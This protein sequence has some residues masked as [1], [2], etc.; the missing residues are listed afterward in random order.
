MSNINDF[1]IENG[2]LTKYLG[3]DSEVV[4]PNGVEVIGCAAFSSCM[5]L[6]SIII[7][8]G[9]KSIREE[10]FYKCVNLKS[11]TIP[12]SV[13]KIYNYAF[14]LC[15]NIENIYLDSAQVLSSLR[16]HFKRLAAMYYITNVDNK[17]F[18]EDMED[19]F[20][21]YIKSQRNK[22]IE[23]YPDSIPLFNYLTRLKLIA[24]NEVDGLINTLQNA[25]VKA[26]LLEYK[27]AE[28]TTENL[29]KKQKEEERSLE[30][31]FG[32][33]PTIAEAK[34]EWNLF[35][36]KESDSYLI[37]GYKGSDTN[38]VIPKMVGK[39]TVSGIGYGAFQYNKNITSVIIP[40]GVTIIHGDA[41]VCCEN[42]KNLTI[43]KSVTDFRYRAISLCPNLTIR[44]PKGSC[45]EKY[46]LENGI[47]IEYIEEF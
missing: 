18:S 32:A 26:L 37:G 20:K 35:A 4:I 46:A 27:N 24:F 6:T 38:I 43:Y 17:A 22:L 28:S 12:K 10:A 19:C 5:G 1:V 25:A 45:A 31:A 33:I 42:L 2:V 3:K 8:D 23:T 21:K 39:K 14:D 16:A 36:L 29:E 15:N 40:D 47:N 30:L 44:T 13:E 9:V 41:F 7:S 11:V 34:K